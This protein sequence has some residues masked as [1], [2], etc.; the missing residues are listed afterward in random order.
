MTEILFQIL[1][2]GYYALRVY[3]YVIIIQILLS[4]TPLTNSSF[5]RLLDK[6]TGPFLH[7]FRGK[8][9]FNNLD[10]TPMLGLILYQFILIYMES[11]L[12]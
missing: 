9:V 5:Y 10:F 12:F 6:I 3:F 8:L 1:L 4:W 7:L 11:V 2:V